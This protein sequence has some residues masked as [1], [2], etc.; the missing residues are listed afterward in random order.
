MERRRKQYWESFPRA[1]TLL[2]SGIP[3]ERANPDLVA[4]GRRARGDT[5]QTGKH[6][7]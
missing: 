4:G 2:L 5:H 1:T 3:S 6:T 7:Q